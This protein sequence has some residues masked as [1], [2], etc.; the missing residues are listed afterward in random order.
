MRLNSIKTTKS[1]G[2]TLIELTV[3]IAVLLGL[4]G[5]LV[6]GVQAFLDGQR[7]AAC[8]L[9]I[10]TAQK[11]VRAFANLNEL[12]VGD[13]VPNLALE[14][15]GNPLVETGLLVVFPECPNNGVY[16]LTGGGAIPPFSTSTT[17]DAFLQCDFTNPAG[18]AT[19]IPKDTTGW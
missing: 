8:I 15:N 12:N 11:A 6:I 17:G 13:T 16:T 10:N 19:H 3:V 5:I 7:R 1:G 4:I 14:E 18:D 9:N 2:F